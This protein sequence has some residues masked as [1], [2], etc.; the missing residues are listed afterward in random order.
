[1][2][3]FNIV[4]ASIVAILIIVFIRFVLPSL[5]K[6]KR[7]YYDEIKMALMLFGY[8]FRDEKIKQI[9]DTALVI[10]SEIESLHI[11]SE[12]KHDLAVEQAIRRFVEEFNIEL[13]PDA[14]DL[15]IRLAV[16][17]LPKTNQ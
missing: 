9:A 15:I 11:V 10:V 17:M 5:K 6:T 1:M 2:L 3:D 13:E 4:N 14:M 16:S 7:T 8:A 12:D